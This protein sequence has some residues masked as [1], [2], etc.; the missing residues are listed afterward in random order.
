MST[1]RS[2]ASRCPKSIARCR[3]EGL[4]RFWLPEEYLA[5]LEVLALCS[6]PLWI[7]ALVWVVGVDGVLLTPGAVVLTAWFL[8]Y[9]LAVRAATRLRQ[10]KHRMPYLLDLLTLLM[11]AGRP[12][13]RPEPGCG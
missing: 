2:S 5:R 6:T 1:G 7:Y 10:I 11:E 9:R 4:P 13:E 3:P 8:R 12:Y